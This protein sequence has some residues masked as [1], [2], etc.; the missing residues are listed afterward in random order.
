MALK[1]FREIKEFRENREFLL[2][3]LNSLTS[4]ISLLTLLK[5]KRLE[6]LEPLLLLINQVVLFRAE[7]WEGSTRTYAV[8][9]LGY[10]LVNINLWSSVAQNISFH[11]AFEI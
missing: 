6:K 9:S 3:S 10:N 1:E 4:L 7:A 8:A 2:I 5:E 11:N